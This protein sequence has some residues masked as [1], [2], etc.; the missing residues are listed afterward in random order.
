MLPG[1][2]TIQ[3]VNLCGAC[4]HACC[5]AGTGIDLLLPAQVQ[6]SI[7]QAPPASDVVTLAL[8]L[9]HALQD[10]AYAA[11]TLALDV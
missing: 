9:H 1:I 7:A 4:T 11:I 6:S 3:G 2:C 8:C 10:W 5:L